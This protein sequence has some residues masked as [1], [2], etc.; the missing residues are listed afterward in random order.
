MT[1]GPAYE[2]DS[3]WWG[4][5]ARIIRERIVALPEYTEA[6][7]FVLAAAFAVCRGRNVDEMRDLGGF[8]EVLRRAVQALP[9]QYRVDHGSQ[10]FPSTVVSQLETYDLPALREE[11]QWALVRA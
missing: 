9:E 5:A 1:R 4:R 7:G 11:L 10:M 3:A 2:S 6:R 8:T